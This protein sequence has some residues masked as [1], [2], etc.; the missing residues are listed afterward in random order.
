MV[1]QQQNH[2]AALI[3]KLESLVERFEKAQGG[4]GPA[5]PA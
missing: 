4:N 3:A 5:A 2:L 1:E